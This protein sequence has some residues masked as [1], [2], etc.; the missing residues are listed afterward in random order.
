VKTRKYRPDTK[1]AVRMLLQLKKPTPIPIIPGNWPPSDYR[2]IQSGNKILAT[3]G[4]K[5]FAKWIQFDNDGR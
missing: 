4:L 3:A 1:C 5:M 2:L